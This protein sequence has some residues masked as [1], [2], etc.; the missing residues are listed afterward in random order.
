[1]ETTVKIPKPYLFMLNQ[2][3]EIEQKVVKLQEQN[4]INRNIERLKNYFDSEAL[5]DGYGLVYHNP[6][7]ENYNETR[8]D[9]DAN[10]SGESHENLEIIE[11]LKPIIYV[12][13]QNTQSVVQKAIVIV[14]SKK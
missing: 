5:N 1:M 12:K 8:T 11:V 9:C 4:S 10:I 2:L 7:G 6:L 13:F 3:F 14:Q